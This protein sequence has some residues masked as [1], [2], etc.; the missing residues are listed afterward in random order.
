MLPPRTA[1]RKVL[2][3]IDRTVETL[4]V[5]ARQFGFAAA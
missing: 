5:I 1:A 3:E 4:G 2:E